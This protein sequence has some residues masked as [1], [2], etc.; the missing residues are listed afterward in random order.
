MEKTPVS[1]FPTLLRCPQ[2]GS[3]LGA[4]VA[5]IPGDPC[6]YIVQQH[7]AW[8]MVTR[9]DNQETIYAGPGPVEVLRSRA[10]F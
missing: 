2:I 1:T 7:G 6:D 8:W 10:P 4:L 3:V 9:Q 5:V